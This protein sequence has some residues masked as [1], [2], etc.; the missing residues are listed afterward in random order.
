M[1]AVLAVICFGVEF[2]L[3]LLNESWTVDDGTVS[4]LVLGLF[5]LAGHFVWDVYGA[6]VT[7]R[8]PTV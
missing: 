6:R 8:S 4:F 5:L 3:Q 2:V 7:R 1:L